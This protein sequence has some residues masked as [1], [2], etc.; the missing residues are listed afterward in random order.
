M[1]IIKRLNRSPIYFFIELLVLST[2]GFQAGA[3]S[4]ADL[5]GATKRYY[6]NQL[7]PPITRNQEKFICLTAKRLEISAIPLFDILTTHAA[8]MK[9]TDFI[10][11]ISMN[12]KAFN[13]DL[14]QKEF[15]QFLNEDLEKEKLGLKTPNRNSFQHKLFSSVGPAQIQVYLAVRL[16]RKYMPEYD[17]SINEITSHLIDDKGAIV[18]LALEIKNHNEI[19]MDTLGVDISKNHIAHWQLHNGGNALFK[20]QDRL[21]HPENYKTLGDVPKTRWDDVCKKY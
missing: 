20:A 15:K 7:R 6:E 4:R 2:V 1:M 12:Q 16:W 8:T 3:Q 13:E 19:Y 9:P 10:Q 5:P 11:N 18:F 17:L 14:V 21:D